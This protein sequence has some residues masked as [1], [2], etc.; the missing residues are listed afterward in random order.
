MYLKSWN[1]R[2]VTLFMLSRFKWPFKLHFMQLVELSRH[3]MELILRQLTHS[4]VLL[5]LCAIRPWQYAG[6]A[7]N[8]WKLYFVFGVGTLE[9]DGE[10]P[11]LH[12]RITLLL[13]RFIHCLS[14]FF[15]KLLS[16]PQLLLLNLL[17]R[18]HQPYYI[19]VT[20]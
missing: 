11:F 6:F 7:Q 13:P 12:C 14:Y 1:F 9:D 4:G 8:F 18:E 20:Y 3:I 17:T 16:I 10:G 2:G 5:L 15:Y 19:H